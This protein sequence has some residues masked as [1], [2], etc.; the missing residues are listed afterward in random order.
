[1]PSAPKLPPIAPPRSSPRPALTT[2][3]RGYGHAHQRQR[4]RLLKLHPLCQRCGADWSK[5]LHHRDRNPHN[6]R[7]ANIEMLCERCH[8]AEHAG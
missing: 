7:S 4:E 1:M 2:T 8:Q 6:R 5:H 3:E